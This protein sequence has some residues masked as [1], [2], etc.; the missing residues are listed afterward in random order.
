MD[1][2]F[3]R[4]VFGYFYRACAAESKE[5]LVSALLDAIQNPG[6]DV[7][8][9]WTEFHWSDDDAPFPL[10]QHAHWLQFLVLDCP[11][12]SA[13]SHRR[14]RSMRRGIVF[15]WQDIEHCIVLRPAG[16]YE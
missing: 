12:K 2:E 10:L 7:H 6:T 15:C 13:S 14:R 8:D 16:K 11:G 4:Q 9:T 1:P 5:N 3:Y